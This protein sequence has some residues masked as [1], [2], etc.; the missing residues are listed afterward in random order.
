MCLQGMVHAGLVVALLFH[1]RFVLFEGLQRPHY[2][3]P[4][5]GAAAD[6]PAPGGGAELQLDRAC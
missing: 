1:A 3:R 2:G 5:R 4:D 6:L